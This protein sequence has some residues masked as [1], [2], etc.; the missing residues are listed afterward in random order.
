MQRSPK[1]LLLLLPIAMLTLLT[2]SSQ[3]QSRAE[4]KPLFR[5]APGSPFAAAPEAGRVAIADLN[6][7]GKPDI[8]YA[9]KDGLGVL[10]GDGSGGFRAGKTFPVTARTHLAVA[11]DFN[12]DGRVDLAASSHDSNGVFVLLG[13]GAGDFRASPGSPFAAMQGKPHNHG[14][15]AGDVNGDG[16]PDITFGHQEN[17]SI[18]VLLGDGKGAFSPAKGSPFRIGRGF[19]PHAL[20][21]F[22]GD[23]K[24][25]IVAPDIMGNAVVITRGDGKGGFTVAQS[26]P[27]RERPYFVVVADLD[28]N[29]RNDILVTHDDISEVAILLADT[30]GKFSPQTL[31]VGERPG[32]AVVADFDRDGKLD[33]AFATGHG[34]AVFLGDGKGG[35]RAAPG[36]PFAG[37]Q[38]DIEAAD[39]N[40][41]GKMDLVLPD[42]ERGTVAVLLGQ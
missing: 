30:A 12:G 35:F 13:D 32:H 23:G 14:L 20:V 33:A 18:A 15:V 17:G 22:D 6:G 2:C 8:V 16:K 26:I 1:S 40:R 10:L 38:W 29:G 34:A 21:D 36:S 31:D 3:T 5:A 11:A 42:F 24:V 4:Q 28:H 7:D 41:D 25:D 27:V 9:G 39:L 19:Y 37:G